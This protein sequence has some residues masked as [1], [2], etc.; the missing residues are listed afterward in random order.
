MKPIPNFCQ[1]NPDFKL[2]QLARLCIETFNREI[3]M[4]GESRNKRHLERRK[5]YNTLLFNIMDCLLQLAFDKVT[6]EHFQGLYFSIVSFKGEQ[7]PFDTAYGY[8]V[9]LA[10]AKA[11]IFNSDEEFIETLSD[12][13]WDDITLNERLLDILVAEASKRRRHFQAAAYYFRNMD[14]AEGFPFSIT[15]N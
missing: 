6:P 15:N 12:K 11:S 9:V 10:R 14:T 4:D 1:E 5:A 13:A 7:C 2:S 8:K 3:E